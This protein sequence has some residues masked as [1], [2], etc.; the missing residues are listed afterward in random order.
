MRLVCVLVLGVMSILASFDLFADESKA[1]SL[2][3]FAQARLLVVGTNPIIVNAVRAENA[4]NKSLDQIKAMDAEWIKEP[5][6]NPF[7][8]AMMESPCANHL[9]ELQKS[10]KKLYAEIFV[11][12]NQG[13]NV[14]MS[15]K[16]SDYWQGDEEKFQKSFL[17]GTGAVHIGPVAFDE[18]TQANLV[19]ISVPVKDGGKV[20]GAITFGVYVEEIARIGRCC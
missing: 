20:I 10:F 12:D 6:I 3:Q 11:M 19:Q 1:K 13:A 9:Q 14:C 8:Q 4:K 15:N 17:D 7:M 5:G 18:S 2:M 16:T